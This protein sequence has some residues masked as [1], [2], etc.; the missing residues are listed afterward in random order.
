MGVM[1]KGN[2]RLRRAGVLAAL[3]VLLLP[4][5]ARGQKAQTDSAAEVKSAFGQIINNT[6][7]KTARAGVIVASLDGGQ[8]LYAHN[9]DELLNPA[10]NVKL[11]TAAAALARMGTEYRFETEFYL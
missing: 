5:G 8:V 11:F 10:S 9:P 3:W 2:P 4:A 6:A 1:R 7:L